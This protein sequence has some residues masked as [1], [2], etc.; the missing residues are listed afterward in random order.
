MADARAVPGTRRALR[1]L[2]DG[3]IRVQVD[4]HPLHC[5]DFHKLFPQIDMGIA[6][7]PLAIGVGIA[8]PGKQEPTGPPWDPFNQGAK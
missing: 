5:A 4:I 1:E 8:K 6:L 7:A 3:T 2:V